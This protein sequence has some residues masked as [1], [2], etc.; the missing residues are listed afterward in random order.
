LPKN[1]T[2]CDARARPR[3]FEK[4][5]KEVAVPS[6]LRKQLDV[7][8]WAAVR[9]GVKV[10]FSSTRLPPAS[11]RQGGNIPPISRI[12]TALVSTASTKRPSP[13]E[14]NL[15]NGRGELHPI[16]TLRDRRT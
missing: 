11:L 9:A 13:G 2:Y 8:L 6:R 7:A 14:S 12:C 4:I 16:E 1:T 3:W 5:R 10:P 15:A